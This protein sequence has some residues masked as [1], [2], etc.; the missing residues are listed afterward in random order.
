MPVAAKKDIAKSVKT[1]LVM[2]QSIRDKRVAITLRN[3]TL[4]T[5][6]VVKV[7]AD[8]KIELKDATV[9]VDR[10]YCTDEN[11]LNLVNAHSDL[12][13][14]EPL[15]HKDNDSDL[16]DCIGPDDMDIEQ[17][18]DNSN[19]DAFEKGAIDTNPRAKNGA[20]NNGT[21]HEQDDY[22]IHH[23]DDCDKQVRHDQAVGSTSG[24]QDPY[25][26]GTKGDESTST[27]HE[28]FVVM[29]SRVRHIDLP[30]DCD[31]LSAT[32]SEIKRIRDR[33][34]RW[35]KKDIIR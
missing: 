25:G 8:M 14:S 9:E 35:S 29:G 34:R 30:A 31:L 28:Y 27:L 10:F 16:E 5:G 1:L 4:V 18:D 13:K 7:G 23:D 11:T 33:T 2:L 21:C 17:S 26:K 32:K 20:V 3:D 12:K 6:T 22:N 15:Q 24:L 19:N